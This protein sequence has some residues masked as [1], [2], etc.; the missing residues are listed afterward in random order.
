MRG[1]QAN[2]EQIQAAR[3]ARGITQEELAFRARVDV[4][5]LRKAER[6]QRVDLATLTRISCT[7]NVDA[8][9]LIMA[10]RTPLDLELRRRDAIRRWHHAWDTRDMEAF[11]SIY[12]DEAVLHLPGAPDIPFAGEHHG[13]EAIRRTHEICWSLSETE[14]TLDED[15]SLLVSDN[16]VVLIAKK[17]VRLSDGR[18]VKLWCLQVF[19]FLPE[20][21]LVI[22]QRVEYDTLSVARMLQLPRQGGAPPAEPLPAT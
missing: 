14:P 20:S 5:T 19:T 21:E 22:D 9:N 7:L 17:G 4:R 8:G 18:T 15:C 10:A 2:G 11:L 3:R 16:T 12:H 13:K 1:V 6:G